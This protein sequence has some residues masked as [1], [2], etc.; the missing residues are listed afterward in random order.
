MSGHMKQLSTDKSGSQFRKTGYLREDFRIFHNADSQVREIPFHY[1]DFHKLFILISGNISYVVEG[2]SYDLQPWD[3]I[4][5]SAGQIHRPVIHDDTLYE[6]II[7]YISPRFFDTF[8][9]QDADLF[10]CFSACSESGTNLIRPG[11]RTSQLL[12]RLSRDLIFSVTDTGTGA[13]LL[14]RCRLTELLLL[15]TRSLEREDSVSVQETTSHPIIRRAIEYI[16]DHLKDDTLSID[17]IAREMALNRSYLMHLFKEQTGYT[18]GS[19]IKEKRL[20]LAS[21]LI[22]QGEPVTEACY[23]SGFPSYSAFYYAYRKKYASPPA[24]QRAAE[25]H[26]S[27]E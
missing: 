8:R 14:R 15:L 23:A 17:W 25:K 13:D 3:I 20:F 21:T 1:H 12:Q 2:R 19:Y 11:A 4:P 6:R 27:D 26:I 5:V 22:S 16:N 9:D 10:R 24:Q 18:I 7:V